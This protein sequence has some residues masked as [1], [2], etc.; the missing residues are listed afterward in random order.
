MGAALRVVAAS[1]GLGAPGE[2]DLGGAREMF[3]R[4]VEVLSNAGAELELAR[5]LAAYAD[6]EARVGR[7]DT[8]LELRR[9]A[10]LI[11]DRSRGGRTPRRRRRGRSP[12]T[13]RSVALASSA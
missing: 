11:R 6:F 12:R 13:P 4:A 8:A 5:T 2:A 1:V 10:D 9:Q 3:D 7:R